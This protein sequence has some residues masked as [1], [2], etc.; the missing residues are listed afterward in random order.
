MNALSK[1][2]GC[3]LMIAQ[4]NSM[5]SILVL[6]PAPRISRTTFE[7]FILTALSTGLFEVGNNFM[8]NFSITRDN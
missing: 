4:N 7:T 8:N 5:D 1:S 3:M 2:H 6:L